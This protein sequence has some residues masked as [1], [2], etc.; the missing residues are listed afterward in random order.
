[1]G[2]EY[3]AAVKEEHY[4]TF[5]M[6]VT[7]PLPCEYGMWLRVRERGKLRAFRDH[8]TIV[9]EVEISPIEFGNYCK[10]LKKPDFSIGSLDRCAGAKAGAAGVAEFRKAG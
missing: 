5:K 7:T 8:G 4:E 1:M 10:G 2:K 6:V 3:I 9:T